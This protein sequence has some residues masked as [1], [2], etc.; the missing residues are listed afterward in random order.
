MALM[1]CIWSGVAGGNDLLD[2]LA[3]VRFA[4]KPALVPGDVEPNMMLVICYK[5]Y[6]LN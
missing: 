3:I 4:P 2:I 6:K 1:K 5:E